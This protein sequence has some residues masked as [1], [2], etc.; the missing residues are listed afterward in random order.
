MFLFRKVSVFLVV[1]LVL[2]SSVGAFAQ[3]QAMQSNDLS[4]EEFGD[5]VNAVSQVQL[6]QQESQEEMVG[7]VEEGGLDV[8]RFMEIQQA[9]MD[10]NGEGES[11]ASEA[12]MEK[13]VSVSQKLDVIQQKSQKQMEEKITESG[14]TTVRYQEIGGMIQ[15]DPQ[16]QQ[17]FQELLQ[18][19]E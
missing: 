5:F 15:N 3:T 13:F 1:V 10:P 2:G 12:E 9:Q 18:A 8:Q 16:L 11:D 17:K 6:I 4:D 7:A 19:E 14:L